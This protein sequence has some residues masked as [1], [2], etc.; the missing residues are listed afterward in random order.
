MIKRIAKISMFVLLFCLSVGVSAY[1]ALTFIIKSEDT[2]IVPDLTGKDLVY[3]LELLTN[4][5]LNT[6]VRGSE[7]SEIIPKNHIIF[8]DPEPGSEIKKD[9]DIRIIISKGPQNV[10]M[11]NLEGISIQ[12]ARIIAEEN[13]LCTGKISRTY[14]EIKKKDIVMAQSPSPGARITRDYCIDILVSDGARP[15]SY[16]MPDLTGT[17]LD[18]AIRILESLNLELGEI[19]STYNKRKPRNLIVQHEPL[20]G[21]Q[22]LENSSVNLTINREPGANLRRVVQETG[23]VQLFRYKLEIGFMRKRVRIDVNCFGATIDMIDRLVKPGQEVWTLVPSN[24][25]A[26]L[27]LYVDNELIKTKVFD[28]W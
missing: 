16:M 28:T 9:R 27:F 3:S 4:L 19:R 15:A 8:Q 7:Y 11:P 10:I 24:K 25:N 21:Y 5:G 23:G 14:S 6:K 12:Q 13:G 20:Y 17:A 18:E 22:V 2:V 26:T 1:I